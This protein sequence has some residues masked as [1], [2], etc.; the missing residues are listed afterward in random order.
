M[1]PSQKFAARSKSQWHYWG[2]WLE[3]FCWN[4]IISTGPSG[5]ETGKGGVEIFGLALMAKNWKSDCWCK[6]KLKYLGAAP[7]GT[8]ITFH[9]KHLKLS[10][11]KKIKKTE[12]FPNF[13][14][15]VF[16]P[17]RMVEKLTPVR[18][19]RL[20]NSEIIFVWFWTHA[21]NLNIDM[22]IHTVATVRKLWRNHFFDFHWCVSTQW[23][24]MDKSR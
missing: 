7:L 1:T 12:G 3:T 16:V 21:K 19:H 4:Q 11:S 13:W 6:A 17:Y 20:G 18:T 23:V 10:V 24:A 8:V 14:N 9:C 5:G 15:V 22:S 2:G